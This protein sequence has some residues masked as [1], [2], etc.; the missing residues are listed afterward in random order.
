MFKIAFTFAF[1]ILVAATTFAGGTGAQKD[2]PQKL[3]ASLD[4]DGMVAEATVAPRPAIDDE[5]SAPLE[6]A[7]T[8]NSPNPFN[9]S[10]V[11]RYALPHLSK[12]KLSVYDAK[13][14]PV[15]IL[16]DEV[17]R[18]GEKS[19]EWL[20]ANVPAGTYFYRLD[21]KAV[22]DPSIRFCQAGKMILAR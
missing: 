2:R 6:Y 1:T 20:A 21:A 14:R 16:T 18:A 7:L 22:G 3:L 15:A 12:V 9:P 11:I 19:V 4:V 8:Q 5:S 13:G 10:T 17:Q